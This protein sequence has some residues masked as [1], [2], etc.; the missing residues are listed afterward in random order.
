MKA[1]NIKDNSAIVSIVT[2]SGILTV[3]DY[4][5]EVN[6]GHISGHE[7]IHKFGRNASAGTSEEDIHYGGG[8]LT[9]LTSA[10]TMEAVSDNVDDTSTGAGARTIQIWGVDGSFIEVTETITMNGTTASTATTTS[11]LRVYRAR[12]ITV[13]TYDGS[14]TGTVTIRVSGAGATQLVLEP[15][16]GVSQTSHYTVAAGHTAYLLRASVSV[17]S[18]KTA[19]IIMSKRINTNLVSA[20]YGAHQHV[21]TWDGVSAPLEEVFVANHKFQEKEDI[22]FKSVAGAVS[23]PLEVD[24]DLLVINDNV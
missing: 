12:V 24:Y 9:P 19:R 3:E 21:H 4:L 16:S 2:R 11:F 23:T 18:S 7:L 8:T 15:D 17:D 13:G 10:S 14:N 20:P 1:F 6:Q 22:W 5:L